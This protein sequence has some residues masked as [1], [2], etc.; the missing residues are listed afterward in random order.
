VAE[1]SRGEEEISKS[2][3]I[4][5]K[6]HGWIPLINS[7]LLIGGIIFFFYLLTQENCGVIGAKFNFSQCSAKTLTFSALVTPTGVK[8]KKY[9]YI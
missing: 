1:V 5:P 7:Y 3:E 8:K 4:Q 2:L 6:P 9:I